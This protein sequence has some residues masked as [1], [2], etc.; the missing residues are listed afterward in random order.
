MDKALGEKVRK[1]LKEKQGIQLDI[2][3]GGAPQKNFINIDVRP[4]PTV[5]IVWNLARYPWPLPDECCIR[6]MASHL[7]EHIPSDMGDGRV[8]PLIELLLKKKL[9][10]PA[11][12]RESIGEY[13]D[14]PRFVRFMNEVWRIMKPGGQFMVAM[15][16]GR[17]QGF[18]QDPTHVSAR[19]ETTW[20]YF[21]PL[22]PH[23][24]GL[25]YGIYQPSPWRITHLSFSP[26]ENM[27]VVLEKRLDDRSCHGG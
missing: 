9:L 20:A 5:D 26:A 21:D 7:L 15:P 18:L 13:E 27:E 11:E 17:S 25:L 16:H 1:L 12:V 10:T 23:T 6:A 3:G 2:G 24:G 19:N 14:V 22:E 8:F 4:L